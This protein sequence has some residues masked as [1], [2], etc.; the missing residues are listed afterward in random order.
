MAGNSRGHGLSRR[1]RRPISKP[2]RRKAMQSAIH[3]QFGTPS[4]VLTLADSPTPEPAAGEIRIRMRLAA[5]HNH[6]LLTVAGTYG[7]KPPLPAIGGS[8]AT[9]TVDALGP[10]VDGFQIGQRVAVSGVHGTWAASF[11]RP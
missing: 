8:E 1:Q 7:Y 9:G 11:C 4:E 3:S 6:D 5:I 10:G 2:P